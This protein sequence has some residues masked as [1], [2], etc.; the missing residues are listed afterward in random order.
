VVGS[1]VAY[2]V[3]FNRTKGIGPVRFRAL[4]EHFG[5]AEAAWHASAAALRAIHVLDGR[6]LDSLLATRAALNLSAEMQRLDALRIRPLTWEDEEYPPL[7]RKISDPPFVL[8]RRGAPSERDQVALTIVGTRRATPYGKAAAHQLAGELAARGVT[9][10]SGLA[11]GVDAAAHHG[12]LVAGGRSLAVLPCGLDLVYPPDHARLA[13]RIAERG[14][15]FSELPLGEPAERSHYVPRNRILSGLSL[16]VLVVEAGDKSG[17]LITADAALDQGREVFAVPGNTNVPQSMGTN[18]LIQ[19]GAKM[20]MSADDVWHELTR[21]FNLAMPT[22]IGTTF[23]PPAAPA[24]PG[25][26]AM[27]HH[28]HR[29]G[30]LDPQAAPPGKLEEEGRA[31]P[32]AFHTDDPHEATL[33][34][35]LRHDTMRTDDLAAAV[36]L[37][38]E[39]VAARLTILAIK[40]VVRE[41]GVREYALALD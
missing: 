16:G 31:A 13:D 19:S 36:G 15:L 22:T 28:A 18:R 29:E 17:A 34:A 38:V 33:I 40:G 11:H 8:Y 37:P 26:A 20:V 21:A 3:A 39:Q 5:S 10:I 1:A 25:R 2:W 41:V 6:S 23:E 32:P 24:E 27:L 4:V 30:Y 7:L 12:A 14:A 9:I 35:C